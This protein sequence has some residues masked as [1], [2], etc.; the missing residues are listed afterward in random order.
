LEVLPFDQLYDAGMMPVVNKLIE[1]LQEEKAPIHGSLGLFEV[2]QLV[3]FEIPTDVVEV[4]E[5]HLV[6]LHA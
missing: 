6:S 5:K 2:L 1:P 3:T 4:S